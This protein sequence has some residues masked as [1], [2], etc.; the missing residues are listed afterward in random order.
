MSEPAKKAKKAPRVPSPPPRE[1]TFEEKIEQIKERLRK[2]SRKAHLLKLDVDL[3]RIFKAITEKRDLY[4]E[5]CTKHF[6]HI[7]S[8][9]KF[10]DYSSKIKDPI[11]LNEIA[12]KI[13]NGEVL[14]NQNYFSL[15]F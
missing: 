15:I 12:E 10:P 2:R 8:D 13:Q 3:S 14:G 7:P 11:S 9:E 1:L 4:G 6:Q 5:D